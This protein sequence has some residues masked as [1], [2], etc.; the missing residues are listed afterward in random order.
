MASTQCVFP[1]LHPGEMGSDAAIVIAAVALI[2]ASGAAV[3]F[4]IIAI[5]A[6][7]FENQAAKQASALDRAQCRADGPISLGFHEG[8]PE[9]GAAAAEAAGRPFASAS[10]VAGYAARALPV[11]RAVSG[12]RTPVKAGRAL[13]QSPDDV[14]NEASYL[15]AEAKRPDSPAFGT[16]VS[17]AAPAGS[18]EAL[19]RNRRLSDIE[20]E[21]LVTEEVD[22]LLAIAA[23]RER[24]AEADAEA[25]A[26][27]RRS[28]IEHH[29][30]S[31]DDHDD[32][33]RLSF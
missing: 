17:A 18:F 11:Q 5:I 27:A 4:G 15:I 25:G 3:V 21:A 2:L 31:L 10:A 14:L 8:G 19:V 24:A 22:R 12:T 6:F 13:L 30:S 28:S 16:D 32:H 33:S 20:R 1:C 29:L 23:A 26:A 9:E 7:I